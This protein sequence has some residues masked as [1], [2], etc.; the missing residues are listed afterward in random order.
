MTYLRGNHAVRNERWR[1]IRY[2]DGTEELYDHERDPNEWRNVVDAHPG[3]SRASC[4]SGCL[5]TDAPAVVRGGSL[6]VVETVPRP[7]RDG[8]SNQGT[9]RR[10]L[11]KLYDS[12]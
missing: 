8:D 6:G 5:E 12:P 3:G 10:R 2:A 1:Y 11:R 9:F 7:R 4:G